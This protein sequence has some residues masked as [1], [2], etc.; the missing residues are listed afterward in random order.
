MQTTNAMKTSCSRFQKYKS[1]KI[2]YNF[3]PQE[4][5]LCLE[6]FHEEKVQHGKNKTSKMMLKGLLEHGKS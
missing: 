6:Y 5:Y 3:T 2:F 1:I 4:V